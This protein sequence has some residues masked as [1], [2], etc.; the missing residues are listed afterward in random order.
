MA[1]ADMFLP[2][3]WAI[4]QGS[5]LIGSK[6]PF[7]VIPNFVPDDLPSR[8]DP[9]P[10]AAQLPSRPYLLYVGALGRHKGL[11]VL[12][13]AYASLALETPLVLI[14]TRWG[15][16]PRSLPPGVLLYEDW[17]QEDVLR[18]MQGSL[19]TLLPS[20]VP[21][22][23]PTVALEAMACGRPVV[24]SRI[25]GIPEMVRHGE[26]GLLV[27]PGD[28]P[29]LAAAIRALLRDQEGRKRL[30]ENGRER[31]KAFQAGTVV[32]RIEAVYQQV[33]TGRARVA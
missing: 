13:E 18:A 14:G 10:A 23:S 24:A 12:L 17:T 4:A 28:A 8:C 32:P 30:G 27:P 29:S 2:V 16:T 5:G 11:P 7:E 21:E 25:G 15:D 3:S 26:T 6:L 33:A 9:S 31:V 20:I 1:V 22:A 19:M